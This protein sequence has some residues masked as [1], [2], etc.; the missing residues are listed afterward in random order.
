M[1]LAMSTKRGARLRDQG[2]WGENGKTTPTQRGSNMSE[3]QKG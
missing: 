2:L 3:G 1:F